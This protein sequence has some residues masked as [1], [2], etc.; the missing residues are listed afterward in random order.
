MDQCHPPQMCVFSPKLLPL[1]QSLDLLEGI[2]G[3]ISWIGK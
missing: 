3:L 1:I 2:S